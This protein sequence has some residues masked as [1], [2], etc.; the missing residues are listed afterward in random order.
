M[1]LIDSSLLENV[2]F[3]GTTPTLWLRCGEGVVA[4][5]PLDTPHLTLRVDTSV[6]SCVGWRDITTGTRS[7]CPDNATTDPAHEQCFSCQKRTG[8]NPAFYHATTVSPQQEARNAEPHLLYLAYFGGSAVKVGISHAARGH[9]RLLEQGARQAIILDT[10]P[11]A[12]IARQYEAAIAQLPGIAETVSV[13]QKLSLL[14]EPF[15]PAHLTAAKQRAEAHTGVRFRSGD[16]LVFDDTYFPQGAPDFTH[17]V[18][19]ASQLLI[20]GRT[21][22]MLGSLLM[23]TQQETTLALPMKQCIGYKIHIETGETRIDLPARQMTLL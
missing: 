10:F 17:L 12:Q 2:G 22:G 21:V 8:F 6:R 20:S 1:S 16:M 5:T 23:C 18:N 11:T 3:S 19:T 15:D 7:R 13:K 9:A 4:Y 14:K